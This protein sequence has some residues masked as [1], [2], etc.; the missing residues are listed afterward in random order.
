MR[1]AYFPEYLPPWCGTGSDRWARLM[2]HQTP[3]TTAVEVAADLQRLAGD[4]SVPAQPL[5]LV[6]FAHGSGSGRHSPRNQAVARALQQRGLATLLADLLSI[7]EESADRYSGHL[8]FDIDLLGRR[9]IALVDWARRQ[10]TLGALPLGVFGA[11]TGAAAGLVAAAARPN[12]VAAVVSRGGRPDLAGPALYRVAAPTLLLVG[13]LDTEV[14][15]LNRRAKSQMHCL[16]SLTIIAGAS[17]LFEE[18]GTLEEVAARA[19]DWFLNHLAPPAYT[20]SPSSAERS[21]P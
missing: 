11:S 15:E 3:L 17:H 7:E 8:R 21:T 1:S 2:T 9:V 13:S 5:G 19:G 20:G 6:I 14:I 12:D 16:V 18:R 4:L 10:E